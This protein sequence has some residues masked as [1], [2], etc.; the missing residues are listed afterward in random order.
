MHLKKKH[1]LIR[2]CSISEIK[3]LFCYII[4][5]FIT[6]ESVSIFSK[7]E[8]YL[9]DSRSWIW[10]GLKQK[11]FF[12][13]SILMWLSLPTSKHRRFFLTD[14]SWYVRPKLTKALIYRRANSIWLILFFHF[15]VLWNEDDEQFI[16]VEAGTDQKRWFYSCYLR[17]GVM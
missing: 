4:W 1:Q 7:D 6:I 13:C 17:S 2:F 8:E 11:S 16:D 14:L 3:G 12:L 10:P 5:R 15:F 9:H